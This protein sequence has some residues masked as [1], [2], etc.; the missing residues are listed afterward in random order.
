MV[1]FFRRIF[2][3]NC[4]DTLRISF[5]K[6]KYTYVYLLG[7]ATK[8]ITVTTD[9]YDLLARHKGPHESFS[10]VIGRL[11]KK[12]NFSELQ[13][14]ISDEFAEELHESV[15]DIRKRADKEMKD[16]MRL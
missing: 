4:L 14:I 16:R 1:V 15:M 2:E 12:G 9:A 6:F 8:S 7:M 13:G 3:D 11:A 5:E 10:D